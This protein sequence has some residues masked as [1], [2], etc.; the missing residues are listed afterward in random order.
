MDD[1]RRKFGVVP[2]EDDED[3]VRGLLEGAGPRPPIA[4]EDLRGISVAA[5]SA[6]QK[7]VLR[8]S[9]NRRLRAAFAVAAGLLAVV[10]GLAVWRST[11]SDLA[12]ATAAAQVVAVSGVVMMNAEGREPHAMVRGESIPPG[13]LLYSPEA[14]GAPGRASLRLP[15][16]CIV[17]LD[18]GARARWVAGQTLE[19]E[20]GALY[21]DTGGQAGTRIEVRTPVGTARD[22][23]TQF[24]IRL[25]DGA[26]EELHI[27]VREGSVSLERNGLSH[28]AMAGRELVVRAGGAP[29]L[30]DVAIHGSDWEWILETAGGFAI[31]GR[32]LHEFLQWV[33]RETGWTVRYASDELAASAREII[34]HGD[35]GEM[36]PDRAPFVVLPSAGLQGD[37]RDGTLFVRRP[38]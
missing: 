20:R 1:Q 13:A 21:A 38:R 15:N 3:L 4:E 8:R 6:W 30:R 29:L 24:V 28:V 37:L 7:E 31:E 32:T 36:R 16:G 33:G 18:T 11:R 9:R 2:A 14:V 25:A 19:L 23:G 10:T 27:L 26:D 5:R 34:L 12:P 22:L 17:R 35:I